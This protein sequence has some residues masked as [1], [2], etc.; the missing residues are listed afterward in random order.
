MYIPG[1]VIIINK[2]ILL[3]S[4]ARGCHDV[5]E[6]EGIERRQAKFAS[7]NISGT[8]VLILRERLLFRMRTALKKLDKVRAIFLRGFMEMG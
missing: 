8:D 7:L 4:S 2:A 5:K 1:E 3:N 6:S